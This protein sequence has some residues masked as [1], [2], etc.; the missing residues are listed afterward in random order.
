MELSFTD[1]LQ[2]PQHVFATIVAQSLQNQIVQYLKK[3]LK[4][5]CIVPR[6]I[7]SFNVRKKK[8][9]AACLLV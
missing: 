6:Q 3:A 9:N 5:S 4:I 7:I 2:F 1:V 8:K